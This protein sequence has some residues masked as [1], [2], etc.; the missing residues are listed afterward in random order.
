MPSYAS[1]LMSRAGAGLLTKVS[2]ERD[3]S[4]ALLMATIKPI[5]GGADIETTYIVAPT[6]VEE[7]VDQFGERETVKTHAEKTVH[8]TMTDRLDRI[9]KNWGVVL[10]GENWS[11]E[12]VT[13]VNHSWAVVVLRKVSNRSN[14][15]PKA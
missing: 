12:N 7:R 15:T 11:V 4:G 13:S 3:D 9:D 8:F 1:S 5:G 14:R 10:D 2:A 6:A